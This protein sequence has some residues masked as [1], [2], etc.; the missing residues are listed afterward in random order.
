MFLLFYF[1]FYK[2]VE[3]EGQTRFCQGRGCEFAISEKWRGGWVRGRRMNIVH[4][5]NTHVC[6]CTC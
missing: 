3:Q 2:I 6:K 4:I 1:F 5:M